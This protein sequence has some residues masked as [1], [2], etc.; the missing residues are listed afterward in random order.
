MEAPQ[1]RD[2]IK[3]AKLGLHPGIKESLETLCSDPNTEVVILSGST[4]EALDEV[5]PLLHAF[6]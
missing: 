4:R 5:P 3:E 1:R 6:S 2:Q